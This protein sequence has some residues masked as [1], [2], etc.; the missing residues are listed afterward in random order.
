MRGIWGVS[1][2]MGGGG[3]ATDTGDTRS[4]DT[5]TFIH[6]QPDRKRI[7]GKNKPKEADKQTEG[8]SSYCDMKR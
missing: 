5:H 6:I 8:Q 4:A 7:T 2:T 3:G 1:C